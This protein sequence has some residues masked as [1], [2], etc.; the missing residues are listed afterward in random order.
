[1]TKNPVVECAF[2]F[3]FAYLSYI[4]SEMLN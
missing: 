3:M 4:V 2:I 1:L